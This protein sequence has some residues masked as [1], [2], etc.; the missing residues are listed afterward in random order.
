[1]LRAMVEA[2]WVKAL[3]GAFRGGLEMFPWK[4]PVL[5]AALTGLLGVPYMLCGPSVAEQTAA[6]GW[7]AQII[8]PNPPQPLDQ[9]PPGPPIE[10]SPRPPTEENPTPPIRENPRPP[11]EHNP[12]PPID[13]SRLPG[14][15]PEG[16][17]RT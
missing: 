1:M 12:I 16:P 6:P 3:S 5:A 13:N 7:L 14:A 4:G 10:R 8:D 11:I 9:F 17:W 15:L 2:Q